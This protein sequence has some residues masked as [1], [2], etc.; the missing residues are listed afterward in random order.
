MHNMH[1]AARHNVRTQKHACLENK[2]DTKSARVTTTKMPLR[3][4]ASNR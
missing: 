4:N 1:E 3:W 2:P